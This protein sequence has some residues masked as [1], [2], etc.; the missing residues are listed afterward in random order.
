MSDN[1]T[2]TLSKH[3]LFLAITYCCGSAIWIYLSDKSLVWLHVRPSLFT[4]LSIGKGLF[5]VVVSG[6]LIS[7]ALLRA[8]T[9]NN[10][11]DQVV[12]ERTTML[13]ERELALE[14]QTELLHTLIDGV[15]AALAM[16]DRDMRYVEASA[17]WC[18]EY[19]LVRSEIIGKS[20]YDVFPNLP[21]RW[22]EAHRKGLSGEALTEDNDSFID[23]RNKEHRLRWAIKPWGDP[24]AASRAASG[25]IIIFTEDVT[26]QHQLQRQL[27]QAQKMEALGTLAGGIAHDFNNLLGVIIG[28]CDLSLGTVPLN[29]PIHG[30]LEHIKAAS[31]RAVSL[32]RQLL[33]FG[34]R[35][36]IFPKVIDLNKVIQNTAKMLQ[37]LVREDIEVSFLH[38]AAPVLVKADAAQIDQ[39]VMNLAVNSRDAMPDGGKIV[40]KTAVTNLDEDYALQHPGVRDGTY[41]CLSVADTGFGMDESIKSK[42]FDPFF[43]TKEPGKGTGLGL[44]TVYG[45]VQQSG[46]HISVYSEP[47]NGTTFHIYFR[48]VHEKVEEGISQSVPSSVP[49]GSET[50]LLVEDNLELRELVVTMLE[51]G[52]YRVLQA[53]DATQALS[54]LRSSAG[55]LELLI[56]DVV[57]P[58]RNG[59]DLLN[60]AQTIHP[61]IKTL[62]ISG[63]PGDVLLHRGALISERAFLQ[64]PFTRDALLARVQSILH[65][66]V[67]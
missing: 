23:A 57:M 16:F 37:R 3:P 34:R 50:I 20:H 28:Y 22:K 18:R 49:R 38:D 48:S 5:Y 43:T 17:K 59:V 15:P 9:V 25:G 30:N 46:G 19:G 4:A 66:T 64:K 51:S 40:I 31:D 12:S 13:R 52:G 65:P 10:T 27:Q 29:T 62:L 41:G 6:T 47:G 32:T 60:D 26:E 63:H 11:L 24:G 14:G 61:G 67:A 58:G 8:H 56:T 33:A 2:P 36:V 35:Q 54:V 42:I 7:L 21:A 55:E 45:I 44:S 1:S 39:I 53:K